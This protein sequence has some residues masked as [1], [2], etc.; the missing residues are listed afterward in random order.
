MVFRIRSAW[1]ARAF[2]HR[3]VMGQ[4][5]QNMKLGRSEYD[6]PWNQVRR[7]GKISV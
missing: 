5:N 3:N 2:E 4:E 7:S 1:S 6:P